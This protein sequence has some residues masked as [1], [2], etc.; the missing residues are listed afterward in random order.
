MLIK[1]AIAVK[2]TRMAIISL[3]SN[4]WSISYTDATLNDG[5]TDIRVSM[6]LNVHTRNHKAY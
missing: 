2:H 3:V 4:R 1:A 5:T 6:V